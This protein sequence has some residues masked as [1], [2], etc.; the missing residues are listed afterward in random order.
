[1]KTILEDIPRVICDNLLTLPKHIIERISYA[2]NEAHLFKYDDVAIY[3][4]TRDNEDVDVVDLPFHVCCF[5]S[6]DNSPLMVMSDREAGDKFETDIWS[7]IVID[8]H[9]QEYIV[10]M[11]NARD[12]PD[13]GHATILYT[14]ADGTINGMYDDNK[15]IVG[16]LQRQVKN[17]LSFLS[18]SE[19]LE[20]AKSV[21]RKIKNKRLGIDRRINKVIYLASKSRFTSDPSLAGIN[22]SHRFLRRGH[23]RKTPSLGKNR[24]GIYNQQGR[25]WVNTCEVGPSNLPLIKKVRVVNEK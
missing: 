21:R 17:Y 23:W 8:T 7:I 6:I 25:T 19:L 15:K 12:G 5:E 9:P 3:D 1:M 22:Y 16:L 10:T 11:T 4:T 13:Q 14:D 20:G 24:D 18:S 2:V